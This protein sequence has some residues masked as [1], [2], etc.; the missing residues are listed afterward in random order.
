MV[1]GAVNM[2][3][4]PEGKVKTKI[5]AI[6]KSYKPHLKYNHI[7]GS[8]FGKGGATDYVC[9][10]RGRYLAVEAKAGTAQTDLQVEEQKEIEAAG[11]I[12]LLIDESNL[13]VLK[14]TIDFLL[15]KTNFE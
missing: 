6:F 8:R 7:P 12:Y 3:N 5:V 13:H 2:S 15:N 4:T 9:C 11:G 10:V 1:G 14:N